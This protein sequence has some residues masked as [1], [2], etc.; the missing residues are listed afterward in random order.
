MPAIPA[1]LRCRLPS[2]T[3]TSNGASALVR[4][5]DETPMDLHLANGKHPPFPMQGAA[6]R[7][8]LPELHRGHRPRPPCRDARTPR[9]H[10]RD[11][12]HMQPA[13]LP[14]AGRNRMAPLPTGRRAVRR[15]SFSMSISSSRSTT[16]SATM[17][18][19]PSSSRSPQSAMTRSATPT[20]WRASAAR[21]SSCCCRTRDA[22]RPSASPRSCA[23][24][25][26]PRRFVNRRG[27]PEVDHQHRRRRSGSQHG[28]NKRPHE[29]RRPGAL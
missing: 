19:T 2:S 28:W 21:N 6:G 13:P 7:R 15:C 8:P 18:A 9:H 26:R 27:K 20:S 11:D 1:P 23:S 5:G 22:T 29:V 25:S 4:G 17:S 14:D 16:A 12:R 3:P 10:R 24:A